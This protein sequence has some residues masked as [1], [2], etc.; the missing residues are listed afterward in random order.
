MRFLNCP[1]APASDTRR[2]RILHT[3][4]T[5]LLSL[6]ILANMALIFGLSSEDRSESSDRSGEI[7]DA[8]VDVVY[9]DFDER[10]AAEQESIFQ[11]VHKFIRKLA[12]FSEFAILGFLTALLAAHLAARFSAVTPLVQWVGPLALCLIYAASDEI[13]QIFTERGPAVR[14]V[15]LDFAGVLCGVLAARVLVWI[16]CMIAHKLNGRKGGNVA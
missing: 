5:V 4:I 6:C 9:P 10:P 13:H 15:L 11:R 7:T 8:V 16:A 3:L 12:H 2:G 14:D 1:I